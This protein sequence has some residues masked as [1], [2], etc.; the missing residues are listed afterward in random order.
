MGIFTPVCDALPCFL[1]LLPPLA[2]TEQLHP[3]TMSTRDTLGTGERQTGE[4]ESNSAHRKVGNSAEVARDQ[5]QSVEGSSDQKSKVA[6]EEEELTRQRAREKEKATNPDD[7]IVSP[8]VI[9][10]LTE[11]T[12]PIGY[13]R[14]NWYT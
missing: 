2:H 10:N 14:E 7:E 12:S 1:M 13:P 4:E 6:S 9:T 3:T 8:Y 5:G 11:F